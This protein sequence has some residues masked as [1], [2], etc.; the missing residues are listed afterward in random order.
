MP[1]VSFTFSCWLIFMITLHCISVWLPSSSAHINW[2]PW[3]YV[4]YHSE[5]TKRIKQCPLHPGM[6]WYPG[7]HLRPISH[8]DT[9]SSLT[10][11]II[12]IMQKLVFTP[13]LHLHFLA[14]CS[15]EFSSLLLKWLWEN[16]AASREYDV[17]TGR[18]LQCWSLIKTKPSSVSHRL[19]G[20]DNYKY[21]KRR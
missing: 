12:T 21:M 17:I 8:E 1:V 9:P 4:F 2:A 10:L 6:F 3:L 5:Q 14:D 15:A 7:Q 16:T 13:T 20:P 11:K 19:S 18:L